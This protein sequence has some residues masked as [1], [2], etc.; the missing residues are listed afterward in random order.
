MRVSTQYPSLPSQ[1]HFIEMEASSKSP[2]T[3]LYQVDM[4]ISPVASGAGW[5]V[6]GRTLSIKSFVVVNSTVMPAWE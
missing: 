1:M 4:L 6:G 5:K 2:Q 3:L